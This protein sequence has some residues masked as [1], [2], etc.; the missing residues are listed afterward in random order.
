MRIRYQ[1]SLLTSAILGIIASEAA[2]AAG[3]I[4]SSNNV[5]DKRCA[6]DIP[7][8]V[9]DKTTTKPNETP[10]SIT[11][12]RVDANLRDDVNYSGNVEVVQ[13]LK[14]LKANNTKFNQHTQ[15]VEATGD[16]FYQDGEITVKSDSTLTTNLKTND[17]TLNQASYHLN[18]SLVRGYAEKAVIGGETKKVNLEKAYVTTCPLD[19]ESWRLGSSE[20]EMDKNEIFGEA[21]HT[22]FWFHEVPIFYLPY[23][24]FP[25]KNQR[26]SGFLYPSI[27]W[28]SN[29]EAIL[30]TPIYWNI[31]PNYDFTFA[32][33]L[34]GR[35]G[36]MFDSEFRYMPFANT[37]GTFYHQYIHHDR[38]KPTEKSAEKYGE[39]WLFS[40]DNKSYWNDQDYGFLINYSKVRQGDFNYIN[41]FSPRI[42]E[43]IDNQLVQE[44][45]L[46]ADFHNFDA[47][48]RFLQYQLMLPEKYWASQPFKLLPKITANYH[49]VLDE[50]AVYSLNFSY[51]NFEVSDYQSSNR[52]KA[53]R[54]HFEP[55][56]E[57]PLVNSNGIVLKATE[58]LFLTHYD[59]S[60][61][62]R[63]M[64]TYTAQG[65]KTTEMD[66]NVDRFLHMTD[67]YGHVTFSNTLNSGKTLTLEP[68]VQYL[69]IPYKNQ[70]HIG[71]YDSTDRIYDFYSLFSYKKYSGLDRIS[72]FNRISYGFTHRVYDENYREIFRFNIGQGYDFTH[73]RVKLYPNDDIDYYPRT[74]V[75]TALNI[76]PIENISAHA[77]LVYNTEEDK[78]SSWNALVNGKYDE[79]SGQI[80]YRFN[81][82]GNRTMK[83]EII[84]LKQLG[85]FLKVPLGRDWNV[86]GAMYYDLEQKKNIDQKIAIKYDSCCYSVG[87][88]V[89][90]YNKPDNYTLTA[91]EETKYG[92]FFE[93][94]GLANVGINSSYS[95]ETK[96]LPYNDTVNLSK[97]V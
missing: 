17:T 59:Q 27:G 57:I 78:I 37:Y 43:T 30:K 52:Y 47:S 49:D 96:L 15:D 83:R 54:Y 69:Y 93:L 88:Q 61:P 81:K 74:P 63:L 45:K 23:I 19:E 68:E 9:V 82:N 12:N 90:R 3:P 58:K 70:D 21:Y 39:R 97:Q 86:I 1:V 73:Q 87:F 62:N 95:P 8:Y 33:V 80:S 31:A 72:D 13:G 26:K 22:V 6:T 35:R 65:F 85:G 79:F 41:D 20:I 5:Y 64:G 4:F 84:D 46:F 66:E 67:I 71:L 94:K 7:P 25:I 28:S 40:W 24:N 51:S 38:R 29:D 92:I 36:V 42:A 34:I 48:I 60:I 75:S 44:A 89:E 56:L 77:D 2:L 11:A 14:H 50:W 91:D 32:P 18:G 10:V 53:A 55:T 16:I 76:S